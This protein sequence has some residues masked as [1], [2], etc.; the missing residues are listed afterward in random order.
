MQG[1]F[2]QLVSTC[3]CCWLCHSQKCPNALRHVSVLL[4]K[5]AAIVIAR[6][7]M[8]SKRSLCTYRPNDVQNSSLY[9]C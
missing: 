5:S 4:V 3:Y 8:L 6:A 2:R 1:P 9:T 7:D